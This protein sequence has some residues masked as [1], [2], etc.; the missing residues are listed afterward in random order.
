MKTYWLAK[1]A[2]TDGISEEKSE[3]SATHEG[4]VF[5]VGRQWSV[6]KVGR[7]VFETKEEA[8]AFAEA[9]RIKRIA[10]LKKQI[11]KLEAMT[12]MEP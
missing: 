5:L 3:K 8:N 1:Y 6:F 9:A 7:D 10:A 12:F 11:Q 2:F 4:Y